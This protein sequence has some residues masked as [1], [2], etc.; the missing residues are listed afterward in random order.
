MTFNAQVF[1]KPDG[2]T[3][4]KRRTFVKS[5]A[6]GA[7]V[8]IVDKRRATHAADTKAL[9]EAFRRPPLSA[10]PHTWWHWMNGN[11]S[12][13][14]ITR[15]LEA[16]ARVGVGGVQMFDVGTGIPKGPVA[17]LSPE[18]IR[19]VQHAASEANRLGL[20]FT[21]HNC[22]GW[23][24]SGGPWVTPDRAMQQLVWSEA[25]IDGGRR[26]EVILP[27]PFAKLNYYRDVMV[28]AFPSLP[29]EGQ[30]IQIARATVGG[31]A[32]D[33]KVLTDWDLAA[34]V[35]LVP[36]QGQRAYLQLE[37]A[38]AYQARSVLI[39]SL[40]IPGIPGGGGIPQAPAS[41]EVS[42]D[43]VTFRK[44][45]DFALVAGGA[46]GPNVPTIASFPAVHAK[47]FR[48][49]VPQARRISEFQVSGS[50]RIPDWTF[51]TNLARRR[52]Q[53][54]TLS[55][56]AGPAIDPEKV[57]DLTP[58]MD[59]EGK[60]SWQA[61]LGRWT[62][63]RIG[64][65][66]TGRMQNA[67]SDTGLG[68]EIDKFSAEAM[69]FHFNKY[70]GDLYEAFRPLAAK[71]LVGALIDSYEVGMQNWTPTFAEEFQKR[72]G[73]DL[74]KYMPSM[75]GRV[76]GSPEIT[77]RFLW[78]LRRA[79]ADVI[80]DNYYGKF[81]ELCRQH[82][83]KSYTEPYGPAN[84][85][86]DELQVGA[87]VDEPMGEFWLRQAGAQWG[88][89]LK[90]TS[91]IAHVWDKPVV[92]AESFTGNPAHSKWQ[93]HPY[94]TKA[95]GDLMY[96]FGL[97]RY[98]F[99]RY[100]Q[101]PHPD[102]V[103]GMTMGPWGFH[104]DRTNTWFEK[105]GPWLQYIARA[106][107][108]L[109]QGK[110]VADLLYL[111]GESAPSEMPNSDNPTKV[112]LQPPSPDGH[113]YDVIHP[114]ALIQRVKIEAGR[115]VLPDGMMYRLL[116]LQPTQGITVEL[117]RK[118]R[119]LVNQGMWL[120]GAPPPYSFGLANAQRNDAELKR[121][122]SE[123]WGDDSA[124]ERAVGKGRVFRP[125]S[126]RAV[127]DKLQVAPD[128]QFTS[129]SPDRDIRYIHRRLETTDIYFVTNHQRRSEE[130]VASFRVEGKRPEF[131]D[132]VTGEI[133][134]AVVYDAANGRV[135]VP[136]RLEPSGSVFVVFGAPASSRA[137]RS[138]AKDGQPLVMT[139]DFAAAP[140]TPYR[141]VAINFTISVWIKPEIELAGGGGG[142]TQE[143]AQGAVG[144]NASNFVVHPPEGD[145][146]YGEGHSA[147]GFT[148]GRD[149]VVVYERARGLFAPVLSAPQPIS[150]WN[151]L[152]V[153]YRNGAPLLFINGKLIKT[154]QKTGR[155]VHP[156]LGS[157]DAN[158]RFVHFE[159]DSTEPS[160]IPESLGEERIRQLAGAVPDPEA[161]AAVET[162]SGGL[163]IWQNG[164][165]QLRDD[166]G[167]RTP[168]R[169]SGVSEPTTISGSWRVTF[170]PKLG[171]PA[172]VTLPRLISLHQHDEAGVRYFSGTATYHKTFAAPRSATANGRRVFLDLGRVEVLA[173][174]LVNG[175]DF[176][177]VWK[178]P[179]RVD[180][181]DALRAG[182]NSLEVRVTNL[183]P[184]RLIGDEQL[185]EEYAF[186]PA[187]P[188]AG[189][190][191]FFV[192]AIREIPKWFVGG[193]AKPEGQRI[194]FTTWRHWRKDSPLLASGLLGPV[195]VL[196]AVRHAIEADS[197]R[198]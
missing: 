50:G 186:G 181:T 148:A 125:Q 69:E 63:L 30:P 161:P 26:V 173:E 138:I 56:D 105:A 100:A 52:N 188:P 86:F 114:H 116:V 12:A 23:S 37:F 35:D 5:C 53:E 167:R 46:A 64:H 154:G 80:A 112:P 83:M 194:T 11:V 40:N 118:L 133:T 151:H 162:A 142:F 20:S 89:S 3:R 98:I 165:Y 68:L 176:G 109:R 95:I 60:L 193:R 180:V 144:A 99:H 67:P 39:H 55:A 24:S 93:E 155:T 185:P 15:D 25:F 128:F 168:L 65:T 156:G 170:P 77:E 111:N 91:S 174:V 71:G 150:G 78:D 102:A 28:L 73:Y 157:P 43:G 82:G 44:V 146:L 9:E 92:G 31:D 147:V 17:T 75:T 48:L 117:V 175:R 136:I 85:P 45:A 6:T 62:I 110:F 141:D 135:R 196:S 1:R 184:N 195:R 124:T 70:F 153:M 190:G 16:M 169:V 126:L 121:I 159:G 107:H 183:W 10:R 21:M 171:A 41:L 163:L 19:L 145:T 129:R 2:G 57:L 32:V 189:G 87:L 72:R 76:V 29:D 59:A 27:K 132:A 103:P 96:T 115:I 66:P 74:R 164:E 104:F 18:W 13:D 192:N 119:D 88:W 143:S 97:N 7:L 84:G 36:G 58:Q 38:E 149:G 122:V 34:G 158:I 182:D 191:G 179:Y 172:E 54:Q 187:N 42:D 127:L 131:W 139:T 130:I 140:V 47:F 51:K 198:V 166:A 49:A 108:M 178:P 197:G 4:M 101:Q 22:P 113:D 152:A 33:A 81:A 61:P 134:P 106:Q 137:L 177:I 79:Q 123:L 90:L 160:L 120:V 8:I 94:A 14:G